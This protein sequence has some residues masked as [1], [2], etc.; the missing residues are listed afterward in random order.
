MSLR[1]RDRAGFSAGLLFLAV[2][3]ASVAIARDYTIGSV[4][5]MGP[6]YFPIALGMLLTVVGAASVLRALVVTEGRPSRIALRPMLA[7]G[8]AIIAFA[9]GIDRVGLIPSVFVSALIASMATPR[10]KIAEAGLV[11]AC[12][13]I[14]SAGIFYYGLKLPVSLF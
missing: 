1:V 5:H 12:L 2:G 13:T 8:A 7:I 10:P 6:G 3:A 14:L 9:A 11:A 4:L